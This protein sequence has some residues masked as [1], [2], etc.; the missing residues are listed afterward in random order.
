VC[1][2][3]SLM[4]PSA[5]CLPVA[6][7]MLRFRRAWN[8]AIS[9]RSY[10]L[11]EKAL[12]PVREMR[13]APGKRSTQ[14]WCWGVGVQ[15][16][17]A[18]VF[19]NVANHAADFKGGGQRQTTSAM[20]EREAETETSQEI[21][22]CLV[23]HCLFGRLVYPVPSR[24]R[25]TNYKQKYTTGSKGIWEKIRQLLVLVSTLRNMPFRLLY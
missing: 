9:K 6:D 7:L 25:N 4:F 11:G 13:P 14:L 24:Q 12:P 8:L 2:S 3:S 19:A 21:K 22:P 5:V 15:N 10:L 23:V 16:R 18:N 20:R 1:S 17:F